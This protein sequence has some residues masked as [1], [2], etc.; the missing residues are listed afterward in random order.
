LVSWKVGVFVFILAAAVH[1][2]PEKLPVYG[3]RRTVDVIRIDGKLD[4]T[5][6][7]RAPRMTGFRHIYDPSRPPKFPVEAAMLWDDANLYVAFSCVDPQPWGR[8]KNRD[9]RLWEEEV[10]EVFLDPDGDGENY[11]ELEVSPHNVVVDL[12]IARPK[13]DVNEALRWTIAG[14]QTAVSRDA[15]GWVTEIA[16]PWKSLDAAGVTAAPNPGDEWRVGLYRIKRPGGSVKADQIAA[17]VTESRSADESRK[18]EIERRLR[19]LRADDEFL[20][21]SLTR[22]ERGFHD[23]E[24]FGFVRFL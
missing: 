7:A 23:P 15:H 4:E 24:R 10:V 17:L 13:G 8:M 6:W 20:A 12:L 9:D 3:A 14:L 19:G 21:W 11:A 22:A 1:A 2:Q 18:K 5:S 16:I